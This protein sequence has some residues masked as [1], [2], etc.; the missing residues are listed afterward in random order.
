MASRSSEV[1]HAKLA[2][3]D[4]SGFP[5]N[6]V[7][8]PLTPTPL[9]TDQG[10]HMPH[11]DRDAISDALTSNRFLQH[12]QTSAASLKSIVEIRTKIPSRVPNAPV[13][14]LQVW[15]AWS[16]ESSVRSPLLLLLLLLLL[17]RLGDLSYCNALHHRS[18]WAKPCICLHGGSA[19]NV[20]SRTHE[21]APFTHSGERLNINSRTQPPGGGKAWKWTN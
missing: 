10:A 11:R 7:K 13:P 21:G 18:A 4:G 6:V 20:G 19:D 1:N 12:S 3:H 17:L 8:L 9:H 16:S 2:G 15:P 14:S 5:M